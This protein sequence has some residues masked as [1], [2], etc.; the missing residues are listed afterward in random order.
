LSTNSF[1]STSFV[2]QCFPLTK[3]VIMET[4][5]SR[6]RF[7]EPAF[8]TALLLS[9]P[10]FG[11]G[12]STMTDSAATLGTPQSTSPTPTATTAQPPT[13]AISASSSP[14][15]SCGSAFDFNHG[16][17]LTISKS[18]LDSLAEKTFDILGSA[19]HSHLVSIN[20]SQLGALKTGAC[21]TVS[22]TMAN[23]H[24]QVLTLSCI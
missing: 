19:D 21:I 4:D 24:Y 1:D 17:F 18:D 3:G 13:T 5:L 22:S 20:V 15:T 16:H 23:D 14:I 8:G 6:R 9:I 2:G 7:L 11:G 12:G 10:A